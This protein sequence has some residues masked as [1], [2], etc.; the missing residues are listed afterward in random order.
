MYD[1]YCPYRYQ[2]EDFE[3]SIGFLSGSFA[4]AKVFLSKTRNCVRYLREVDGGS[5]T[6]LFL[7]WP[8]NS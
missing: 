8:R 6:L 4:R 7:G 1:H 5:R 3:E 2:Q